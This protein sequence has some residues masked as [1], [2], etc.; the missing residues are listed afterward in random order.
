MF[1]IIIALTFAFTLFSLDLE[2]FSKVGYKF[3]TDSG[4]FTIV[5]FEKTAPN[6]SS[7]FKKLFNSNS[8]DNMKFHRVIAGFVNQVGD[9][10]TKKLPKSEW[11]SGNIGEDID[12]EIERIHFR[13]CVAAARKPDEINKEMRS[14]GSQFYI[15]T[16]PQHQLDGKYTIFGRVVEG[17]DTIDRINRVKTDKNDIPIENIKII[18]TETTKYLDED[19]YNWVKRQMERK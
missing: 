17:F 1:R 8:Y 11:G 9:P 16:R 4:S 18:S 19:E 14:S 10:N 12:P 5:L 15:C 3:E 2:D 7:N 13:G 6:H